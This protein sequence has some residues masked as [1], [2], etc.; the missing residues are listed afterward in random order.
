MEYGW[1]DTHCH[2]TDSIFE[3]ELDDLM[4]RCK[5]NQVVRLLNVATDISQAIKSRE[6][7]QKY[8]NIDL[9]VGFHPEDADKITDKEYADL[10]SELQ[11]GKYIALGEIGLDYYWHNDN[12]DQQKELF[13]RQI[14]LANKYNLPVLIHTRD[15]MQD[16]FDILKEHRVTRG[17]ILH[18]YGGSLEM[19]KE[20]IKLGYMIAFGGV[21]TFKNSV[22]PKEVSKALPLEVLLTET[23]CPYMTPVP[24]RGKRNEPMYVRYT[25]EYIAQL[26]EIT[27]EKL[28]KAVIE[29]YQ[30]LFGVTW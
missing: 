26:K 21:V 7:A 30:R 10:E 15:A 5:E 19:A 1:I 2:I 11:S 13:I 25:G 6:Y 16:T 14:E 23:D 3:S 29:N 28:Q 22:T 12:K 24:Y 20:Y 17:G 18:C 8:S 9:A 4:A 27:N